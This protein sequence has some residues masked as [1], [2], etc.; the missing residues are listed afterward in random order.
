MKKVLTGVVETFGED[1]LEQV[2]RFF[3][4]QGELIEYGGLAVHEVFQPFPIDGASGGGFFDEVG[5]AV[6]FKFQMLRQIV[7]N[8][9][10]GGE[11]ARENGY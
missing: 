7:D 10:A 2:D 3:F 6:D 11:R 8:V 9:F 1:G 4:L 5:I